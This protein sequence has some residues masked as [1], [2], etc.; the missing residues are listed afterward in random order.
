LV[1]DRE[2]FIAAFEAGKIVFFAGAGASRDSGAVMPADVLRA[3]A[4][5][6]LPRESKFS[7]DRTHVL[8]ARLPAGYEGIQPELFYENL[9]AV[10]EDR[11][12]LGLWRVLSP[13][14]LQTQGAE[15]A[16]NANHL[17]LAAY[18]A[19]T[20][21]PIFTTNFDMLFEAAAIALRLP[22]RTYV[23]AEPSLQ[24]PCP[25][26]VRVVKL[27]GS[28]ELDDRVNL[29]SLQSTMESI[30]AVDEGFVSAILGACVGR[31]LTFVGYSGC[32]IDYFPVLSAPSL[33]PRPFWFVPPNDASTAARARL[34]GARIVSQLPG[35]LFRE[36]DPT[37]PWKLPEPDN[38][39][40]LR[41]L[42]AEIGP[43][44]S[45]GQKQLLLATCLLAMGRAPRSSQ[46]L[47]GLLGGTDS[48]SHR[49]RALAWLAQARAHD[50][51]S[52]YEGSV[53]SGEAA[54][55][56]ARRAKRAADV[57]TE[58]AAALQARAVY[59]IE[60]SRQQAIGPN[61]Q[62]GGALDWTPPLH[63][64][65][66]SLIRGV[67][68]LAAL[69]MARRRFA[70]RMKR[71]L[72]VLRAEHAINDH[73]MLLVARAARV[74]C[75]VAPLRALGIQRLFHALMASIARGALKSRDYFTYAGCQKEMARLLG[76]SEGAGPNELYLLLRDPLNAGIVQR[77]R[78]MAAIRR[79]DFVAA[80]TALQGML[81][82]ARD[83]GSLANEV[84]ALCG[85]S[86]C[87]AL[88]EQQ[89]RRLGE[90][91]A[92]IAGAG[93]RRFLR[94]RLAAYV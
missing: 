69:H 35:E 6:F 85:L 24:E 61:I 11:G 1:S 87:L 27:H 68:V 5:L 88:D 66:L 8:K 93:Y 62:F 72:S 92:K 39:S 91:T 56:S 20:G 28:I 74:L 36:R 25:G 65:A 10:R 38:P 15:L 26:V 50:V 48:L 73:R 42:Q 90:A 9:L 12:L 44:L 19:R 86:A 89:R 57:D 81:Q 83:C 17:A 43:P 22:R 46:I 4:K 55:A 82:A 67:A 76:S 16:P 41:R 13:T 29:E 3:S 30:T 47:E 71:R 54:L 33:S 84:K 7:Q 18:A 64:L 59:Q 78:S 80:E 94:E 40:L 52:D 14:W 21:I 31:T 53:R 77:D 70:G 79:G 32:D 45:S 63:A 75:G 49:D 60:M 2:D 51:L 23:A 37:L 34:I 58:E